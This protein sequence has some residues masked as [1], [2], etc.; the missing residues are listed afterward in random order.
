MQF[1]T[2]PS[3][4]IQL[5]CDFVVTQTSTYQTIDRKKNGQSFQR[6]TQYAPAFSHD[7]VTSMDRDLAFG[8]ECVY[9]LLLGHLNSLAPSISTIIDDGADQN[10]STLHS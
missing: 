5:I 7:Y 4:T 2:L 10:R 3:L 8:K 1:S 9:G 6:I